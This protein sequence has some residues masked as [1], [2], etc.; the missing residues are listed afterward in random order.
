MFTPQEVSEKTFPKTSALTAG[1]NMAAVDE[2]LDPLTEDYTALYKENAALKAKLKVLAEKIEEYRSTE[3]A[4]RTTL[5]TAQKLA[6]KLVQEAQTQKDEILN[7][8]RAEA[9][10]QTATLEQ[11]TAAAE[12]KLRLAQQKLTEFIGASRQLCQTQL[13]FLTKLPEMD[14]ATAQSAPTPSVADDTIRI[15]EQDILKD[16][17]VPTEPKAA[18]PAAPVQET[19]APAPAQEEPKAEEPAAPAQPKAE[20]VREDKPKAEK[21]RTEK[22]PAEKPQR[23]EEPVKKESAPKTEEAQT[24]KAPEDLGEEVNDERAQEIRKFLSGLLQQMEVQAEVKVYLPEKGRYKVFLEGQGLGAIIGRRGETLDA[25]QQLTSYSVNRTG[26]RGRVQLD[27]DNYR[28]KR[29]QSLERLA[30]KVAGKGVKY[31]RSVTLEP[32]N[33]YERHVIHTAL[34]KVPGVTT[35]STGVDPNRRVIVA[36]DREKK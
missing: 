23:R 11:Q 22:K 12:Q 28:A 29:E 5:V 15:I 35:Y 26:S 24:V 18:E 30:N 34:Q 9:A 32:M 10:R 33:A 17:S 7:E 20:K 13:D 3:D 21:P 19:A 2:F 8:A 4:M 27:A 1:Y 36:Y 14:A 25:I 16:F 31:R 6:T